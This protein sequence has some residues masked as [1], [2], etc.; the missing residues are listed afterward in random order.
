MKRFSI[1][2]NTTSWNTNRVTEKLINQAIDYVLKQSSEGNFEFLT[3]VNRKDDSF[4]QFTVENDGNH[5]EIR[6]P[7]INV[8]VK[9][10]LGQELIRKMFIDF[11]G[12]ITID[13][14]GFEDISFYLK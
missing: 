3:L 5:L 9:T 13:T 4:I 7:K 6:Y 10:V 8:Y 1:S 14:S 2:M 11:Y 12:G